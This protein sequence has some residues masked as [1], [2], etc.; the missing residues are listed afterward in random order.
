MSA[1]G[2][3]DQVV[4]LGRGCQPAHQ[5]R[6]I[7]GTESAHV[8]DWL[9]T[10]DLGLV[11]LIASDLDRFFARENLEV[12][13]EGCIIDRV[14]ETQF[15][16]EFPTGCDFEAQYN[17]NAGRFAA[18]A[19]RW[20]ELLSS[21]QQVL[22]VR[23]H[24]WDLDARASATRL[25]KTIAEQAPRLRFA[26]LYLHAADESEWGEADIFNHRLIQP[27]PYDW[28]GDDAAWTFLVHDALNGPQLA[29]RET[30]LDN[31]A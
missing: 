8:F 26:I 22:F 31:R 11:T 17:A 16:H 6:R 20:R 10:T 5:I 9:V 13:P 4:S 2:P 27:E 24:G 28:K 25:R 30:A 14:T 3:Y 18:L 1:Y 23:Q 19:D 29:R 15:Q 7:L 12:G 21:A